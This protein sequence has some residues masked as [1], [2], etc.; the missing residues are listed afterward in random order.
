M[1]KAHILT[2][3]RVRREELLMEKEPSVIRAVLI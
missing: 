3:N 1:L 2:D